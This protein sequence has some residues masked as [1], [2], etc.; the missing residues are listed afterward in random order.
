VKNLCFSFD[1]V[2]T[3]SKQCYEIDFDLDPSCLPPNRPLP[4]INAVIKFALQYEKPNKAA[5]TRQTKVGKLE[6]VCVN[7]TKT[8]D[9]HVGKLLAINGT[10]LPTVFAPFTHTNSSLP[11]LVC[12]VKAA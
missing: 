2:E 7:G 11:T 5:F 12:R 4:K 10:C 1:V 3:F 8:V 6:L 9:K